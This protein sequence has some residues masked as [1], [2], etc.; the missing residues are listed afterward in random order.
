VS[1]ANLKNA[2]E[3]FVTKVGRQV[4]SNVPQNLSSIN[5][6]TLRKIQKLQQQQERVLELHGLIDKLP[7]LA[8]QIRATIAR[9]FLL[10]FGLKGGSSPLLLGC[11]S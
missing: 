6:A 3:R 9:F 2:V 1:T 8:D 4:K 10:T 5:K 11:I 7:M